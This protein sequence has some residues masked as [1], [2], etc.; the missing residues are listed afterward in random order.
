VAT[1]SNLTTTRSVGGSRVLRRNAQAKLYV[2]IGKLVHYLIF[3]KFPA[4]QRRKAQASIRLEANVFLRTIGREHTQSDTRQGCGSDQS[5]V[6]WPR[7]T[8]KIPFS[9]TYQALTC[10]TQRLAQR[11][12]LNPPLRLLQALYLASRQDTVYRFL[13]FIKSLCF[14]LQTKR[15]RLRIVDTL[16]PDEVSF[17]TTCHGRL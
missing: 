4:C 11:V 17:S 7:R 6:L 1:A 2:T 16:M 5:E 12:Q 9:V 3:R 13:T 10:L 8:S 14:L 15:L